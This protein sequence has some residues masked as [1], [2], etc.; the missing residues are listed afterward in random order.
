MAINKINKINKITNLLDK[1]QH[2]NWVSE[3]E[4][5]AYMKTLL[6]IAFVRIAPTG[7]YITEIRPKAS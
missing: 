2:S 1:F 4:K 3:L 5:V 7:S 6:Y